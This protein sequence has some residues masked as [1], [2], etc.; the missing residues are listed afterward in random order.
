MAVFWLPRDVPTEGVRRLR[1]V[2]SRIDVTGMAGFAGAMTGLLVF[3]LSLPHPD[4]IALAVA[5]VV[6]V[7]LVF[8]TSV[9]DH[10]LQSSPSSWS[11]S[12]P[13]CW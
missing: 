2:V 3:L 13:W 11:R 6:A 5:V 4:W 12:A 10:G 1:E 8:R 9:N 7:A